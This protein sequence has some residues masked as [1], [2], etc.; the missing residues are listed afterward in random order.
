MP[1]MGLP[2]SPGHWRRA[3]RRDTKRS[4]AAGVR[5][6]IRMRRLRVMH[7]VVGG[8]IGGA[9]RVVVD[10][11]THPETTGADHHVA[12]FTPNRALAA[13]LVDAGLRVHDR[14]RV[15]ESPLAYL[16]RSLGPA[17][18][19]WLSALVAREA[20]DVVHTHTFGSHVLG[21]RAARRAGRPQLRTEHHVMHYFDPSCSPFTRWAAARTTRFVAVSE[22]VRGVVAETAPRVASRMAVVRNGVDTA[23]FALAPPA[24]RGD[25]LRL[26]IVCRLT[27]WKRVHLAVEAAASTRCELVV[28]G[29]GEERERLE[30][31]AR[32]RRAAVRFVGYQPDPRP[33]VAGCDAVLSTAESEPLGL[34]VLEALSMGRPVIAFAAGGIPEIVEHERTGFLVP[35]A[36][37]AAL[38][39]A[40]ERAQGDR[41]ALARMGENG[42][43]F[44]V[45]RCSVERMC[46]GYAAA[47]EATAAGA[48]VA[49]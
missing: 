33:F 6:P 44:A 26:G 32:E 9:E 23:Y 18:A 41:A 21:T 13:Y 14:G 43:R 28:I 11:S 20:I 2:R 17:D 39:A 12:L 5:R 4:R 46:E 48:A 42:R 31:M 19:A 29:D 40:V 36:T 35:D 15:R 16:Y 24:P 27:A 47:Y 3:T 49:S 34:S 30:A 25:A 22:Y 1:I 10:L 45:E 37:S 8:D 38:S 7:V